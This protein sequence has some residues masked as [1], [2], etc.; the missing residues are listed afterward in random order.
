MSSGE[1]MGLHHAQR[2]GSRRGNF[3]EGHG[4]WSRIFGDDPRGV[5]VANGP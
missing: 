1:A 4:D 5:H 2:P 3:D